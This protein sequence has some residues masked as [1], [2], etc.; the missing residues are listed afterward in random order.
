MFFFFSLLLNHLIGE[1]HTKKNSFCSTCNKLW[2]DEMALDK[3][4]YLPMY[5]PGKQTT[6][7]FRIQNSVTSRLRSWRVLQNSTVALIRSPHPRSLHSDIVSI[8]F[9]VN[10]SMGRQSTDLRIEEISSNTIDKLSTGTGIARLV[11]QRGGGGGWH[12]WH[13]PVQSQF[14]ADAVICLRTVW[15]FLEEKN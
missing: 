13:K 8:H 6:R 9:V 7:P 2:L 12:T 14:K 11:E 1:K 15:T 10:W 4:E 5:Q 3:G